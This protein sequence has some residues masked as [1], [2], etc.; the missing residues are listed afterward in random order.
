MS[1][2]P[3]LASTDADPQETREWLDALQA[4]IAAEGPERAHY[5]L[6]Q[7]IAPR[8]HHDPR[9]ARLRSSQFVPTPA[10]SSEL[11]SSPVNKSGEATSYA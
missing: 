11:A 2:A 7:L 5:L 10:A 8:A 3:Q 9:A 6:E 1:A 4:V